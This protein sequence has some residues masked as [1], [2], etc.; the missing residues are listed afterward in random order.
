MHGSTPGRALD[1]EI[2]HEEAIVDLRSLMAEL[3]ATTAADLPAEQ[4]RAR[5]LAVLKNAVT[6]GD[7]ELRRRFDDGMS[8]TDLVCAR[9]Y[10]VDQI[11]RLAY[12]YVTE[13]LYPSGNPSKGERLA[14]VA[15]GGYGRGELAPHSDVDLLFL[16]PY[17]MPPRSEQVTEAVLYLLWD[18]GFKVGQAVRSVDDCI[19]HAKA[20][21]T[22]RTSLLERRFLCGD[23]ALFQE[24]SER[25]MKA[26][27]AGT[28]AEFIEAKLAERDR[29][30]AR[31]GGSRY[32]LEPNIK[33]GKG[34]LRDLHTLYWIGKYLY[35]V[36][37]VS[38]LVP[39]GVLTRREV[40]RFE[41]AENYLWTLR[42]HLHYQAGRAEERL[43]YDLQ[44]QVAPRM[45]YKAHAGTQDVERLMKHYFLIAK[46]VGALTRI[47]CAA[48]EAEHKRRP[49]LSLA[50]LAR[51][52][53]IAGF[54]LERDR[55][56]VR[57]AKVF[58]DTPLDMLR[59]FKVAQEHDLDIHPKALHWITRNL[60]RIDHGLRRDP[61]ANRI[62]ME[63]L[64]SKKNPETALRRLN[65]A[66]VFGRF[67]PDFG[68]VVAQ[69]QYN[70][71]HHYTVDEH[72]IFAIGILHAIE[73]GLLMEEA[74]IASEVVHKVLSRRVLYLAVLFHD[75][76]KGRPGD[77]SQVGAA[78]AQKLCPRLGLS[79]EETETVAWLVLHHL[80]MS[81]TAF[82]RDI[83]DSQTIADFAELV[84]SMERLRLLLVLTVAD[85]RAVGPNTWTSWKAALLRELYWRTEEVLS[86]GLATEGRENRVRNAQAALAAALGDWPEAALQAHIALGYPAYWLSFDTDTHERHARMVRD[87]EAAGRALAIDTQI[88]RY[89]EVTEI[90]VYTPDQPGLF[91]Q[92]AGAL[93]VTGAT[94]D[95]AKICTLTNGAALDVFYVRDATGG[96]FVR[97]DKLARLSS[98]IERAI[99]GRL[100]PLQELASRAS[101]IPSRL[102]VF[103]VQPRVLIDN[104]AS[105]AYTV[106]EVNGRDRPGL[107]YRLTLALTQ[108][109]LTIASA[110]ISTYG[111][112][113]VDVFYLQDAE[114]S[115]IRDGARLEQIRGEL[116]AVLER[117]RCA[118]KR[119]QSET[120]R[121][122]RPAPA[123]RR[124]AASARSQAAVE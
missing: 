101:S 32:V 31:L 33:D 45:G 77:H 52:R 98:A 124:G 75:M 104:K 117:A 103:E 35:R 59:I 43:T 68:R 29:R 49:R 51:R 109:D 85:I 40:A 36:A 27:Q 88:D 121:G 102:T 60:K 55:L 78:L 110:M 56:T 66:G 73:K 93:A 9:C 8:G 20:D 25:F 24:L 80:A 82:R 57:S 12:G 106:I 28:G 15:V 118:A 58:E 87:A 90:T 62:F 65:E 23:E 39:Q 69:M 18:I 107:L 46:D 71:Y 61:E 70:M 74:P 1:G 6:A 7:G 4:M 30:H 10:M 116:L 34:G 14:L 48:L 11:V 54:P 16:L 112:R 113:V 114:G 41:K 26:V 96:P 92:I 83:D 115:K 63:I 44:K 67:M 53:R 105:A 50:V 100:R 2:H 122:E 94:I 84:Q 119:P 38:E 3:A 89:R 111:E 86:G 81:N 42:C 72:T 79:A 108:L 99:S 95:A 123:R 64:T 97:P 19:R 13:Q 76:A 21:M 5:V 120:V 91:S 22:I 47:F 37:D 17:K